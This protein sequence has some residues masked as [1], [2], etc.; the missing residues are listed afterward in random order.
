MSEKTDLANC[1]YYYMTDLRKQMALLE[2]HLEKV[3]R[4]Y[5]E[6]IK[7]GKIKSTGLDEFFWK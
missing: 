1:L 7:L 3:K 4:V 2:I 6:I 5:D